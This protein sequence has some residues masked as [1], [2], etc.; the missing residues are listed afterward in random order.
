MK[1]I[2]TVIICLMT[3]M[4]GILN[5]INDY[6]EMLNEGKENSLLMLFR[7]ALGLLVILISI[8]VVIFNV[9]DIQFLYNY[10]D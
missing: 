4:Y 7:L 2:I 1:E 9:F 5:I 6:K 3:L 10:L 8:A